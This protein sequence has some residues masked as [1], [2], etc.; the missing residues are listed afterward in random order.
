MKFAHNQINK[1]WEI[2]VSRYALKKLSP[3]WESLPVISFWLFLDVWFSDFNPYVLDVGIALVFTYSVVTIVILVYVNILRTRKNSKKYLAITIM[4][5][6]QNNLALM[7]MCFLSLLMGISIGVSNRDGA[8]NAQTGKSIAALFVL[9]IGATIYLAPHIILKKTSENNRTHL[10]L[11]PSSYQKIGIVVS[12]VAIGIAGIMIRS[13]KSFM[14]LSAIEIFSII[15]SLIILYIYILDTYE[16]MLLLINK[17]PI[18][19]KSGTSFMI[20]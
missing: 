10:L 18:V 17:M 16:L 8:I 3:I 15:V 14:L 5:A 12:G 13:S 20:D 7:M 9:F 4:L 19:K 2:K 1:L 11:L 6:L